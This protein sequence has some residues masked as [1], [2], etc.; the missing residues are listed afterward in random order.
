MNT[1]LI[2]LALLSTLALGACSNGNAPDGTVTGA[3]V[4]NN[5]APKTT[6]DEAIA[7][8]ETGR[9]PAAAQAKLETLLADASLSK[10]DHGRVALALSRVVEKTD[11]ERAIRLTEEAV[12][13]DDSEAEDRLFTLLSGQAPPNKY[14]RRSPL[15][16]VTPAARAFAKY[17]P[18]AKPD[19]QVEVEM[20]LFGGTDSGGGPRGAFDVGAALREAAVAECG[21]CD[22]VKVDIHTHSSRESNWSAIPRYEAKLDHALVVVYADD[23]T[24]PPARYQKWVAAPIADVRAA[25]ARGEGMFAVKERPGAPPL[26][27]IA[28]PRPSQFGTV[29]DKLAQTGTFAPEPVKVALPDHLLPSEIQDAV[30]MRFG[31]YR[32]CYETMLTRK[33]GAGGKIE[34]AFTI[35]N[36]GKPRDVAVDLSS[37]LQDAELASCAKAATE[38]LSFPAWSTDPKASTTVKY[39]IVV[40]P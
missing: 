17:W 5:A 9:D 18:A 19:R 11:L 28:A 6:I 7:D 21:L 8:A 15:G 26:V 37:G 31:A 27:L 2:P 38:H 39:P 34:L 29:E 1:K 32:K 12:A 30:R 23:A 20:D 35:G 36:D 24:I 33:P 22:T 4:A 13:A 25:L 10:Q 14:A 16:E 3:P 40:S